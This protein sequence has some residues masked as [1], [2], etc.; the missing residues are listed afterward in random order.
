MFSFIRDTVLDPFMGTGTTLLAAARSRR[1]SI[2]VEI[3]PA[4]IK[5]AK[6]RLERELSTLFEQERP[7]IIVR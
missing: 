3:E 1:N 7:S 2:G 6:T 4:Y 5:M